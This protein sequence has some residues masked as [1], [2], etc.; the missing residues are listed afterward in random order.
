M[1]NQSVQDFENVDIWTDEAEQKFLEKRKADNNKSYVAA[2]FKFP[3]SWKNMYRVREKK[4]C[5]L[6]SF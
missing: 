6:Y 4:K 5:Y 1:L 2:G 3:Q